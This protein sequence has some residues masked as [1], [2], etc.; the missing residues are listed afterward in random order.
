MR[1]PSVLA[2]AVLTASLG[3]QAPGT[4]LRAAPTGSVAVDAGAAF[5]AVFAIA[6]DSDD[7]TRVAPA[8]ALPAGWVAVIGARAFVLAPRTRD[9]WLASVSIPRGAPAGRYVLRGTLAAGT[10]APGSAL[11]E[12]SV[13]LFVRERRALE[14]VPIE[15][16]GWVLAGGSYQARFLVLNRG[17]VP[18]SVA[19]TGTSSRGTRTVAEPAALRLAAGASAAVTVRVEAA[20]SA[21]RTVD[22]VIQLAVADRVD[23]T[24]RAVVSAR[25]TVVPRDGGGAEFAT[26]PAFV[27]VR[28]VGG[29]SGVSP[30]VLAGSGQLAD[31]R[32]QVD[33]LFQAPTD[34][35][36]PWGFGERD[37]YRLN[38]QGPSYRMRLGDNSYGRSPLTSTGMMGTGAELQVTRG[39]LEVGAYA[40]R[41]RWTPGNPAEQA[42]FASV[43]Q[44]SM[45]SATAALLFRESPGGAL[46]RVASAGGVATLRGFGRLELEA[47]AS[48]SAPRAGTGF[49][50][51]LA[52]A[53][54]GVQYD[55]RVMHGGSGLAGPARGTTAADAMVSTHPWRALTITASGGVR[56]WQS[57]RSAA[58]K[59]EQRFSTANLSASWKGTT[60]EYGWLGRSMEGAVLP[61]DGAQQGLRITDVAQLGRV[62]VSG[63]VERGAVRDHL[64]GESRDYTL[65]SFALRTALGSLGSASLSGSR[66]FGSTLTGANNDVLGAGAS[67]ELRLPHG[68][69]LGLS[70]NAQR[71]TFGVLDSSGAWFSVTDARLDRRFANGSSVGVHARILQT[72]VQMGSP[73][74][75]AVY[76]EY[77]APLRL[78]T[79]V[80]RERG[81]AVGMVRDAERGRPL[82]GV[83]VRLGDQADVSDREGRVAF[84]GLDARVYRVSVEPAGAAA[85]AL[86]VGDVQVDLRGED[87]RPRQFAVA[88]TRGAHV[89]ALVR[90]YEPA[91][92]LGSAADTSD[93]AASALDGVLVALQGA[94]D[95]IYLATTADGHVNFG[96][97]A[98]G[99]WTLVVLPGATPPNMA[100]EHDRFEVTVQAGESREVEFRLVPVRRAVQMIGEGTAIKAKMR[101]DER[102]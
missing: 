19:L 27:S 12:D 51:R 102:R 91:L 46:V 90:R 52:G 72:P 79:G 60:L 93:G 97:V 62:G 32:T 56:S 99:E 66:S 77:R 75:S 63:S 84:S 57:G 9:T 4:T 24:S 11:Q 31:R 44:D 47:A 69:E 80:S 10:E 73:N 37:E 16:P 59:F 40:Q 67:V 74:S 7:S 21:A 33:F 28:S 64:T 100:F 1:A 30:L 81:R 29:A 45:A 43:A 85:G 38:V 54:S 78:P 8:L 26:M 50:A 86:L 49:S 48:D 42:V 34:Q 39:A 61:V 5:T 53:A 92:T 87:E 98:P 17:N 18:V 55:V 70:T 83:L 82:A 96:E 68:F 20:P 101:N 15:A 58:D 89:A 41:L 65:L 95:T 35:R 23:S 2:L 88:V 3:A 6:N 13:V 22:D 71:A 14:A 36:S 25:T 94:R 76:L